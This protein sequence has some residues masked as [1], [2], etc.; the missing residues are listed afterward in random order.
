MPRRSRCRS[1]FMLGVA[2]C[3][4]AMICVFQ[5]MCAETIIAMLFNLA[6]VESAFRFLIILCLAIGKL[7]IAACT[8]RI[9]CVCCMFGHATKSKFI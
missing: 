3:V 1:A 4:I 7:F 9:Y 5:S 8:S 6:Y 2:F